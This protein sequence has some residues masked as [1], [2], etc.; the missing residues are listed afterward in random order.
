MQKPETPNITIPNK[1]IDVNPESSTADI[2]PSTEILIAK[3]F[4][5]ERKILTK[6]LD[7]LGYHY[8]ILESL[9]TL[10]E[11]VQSGQYK[12]LFTDV[13]LLTD[14]IKKYSPLNIV[15]TSKTKKEINALMQTKS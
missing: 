1:D 15:T 5:L 4:L 6:V 2:S 13:D 11:K 9:D 14:T 12:I 7:N 10:E 3:K 8:T